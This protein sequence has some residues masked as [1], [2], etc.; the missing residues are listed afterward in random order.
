[1]YRLDIAINISRLLEQLSV[2]I[3]FDIQSL[4]KALVLFVELNSESWTPS[5]IIEQMSEQTPVYRTHFID[6]S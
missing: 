1:M 5:L 6:L 3:S 4:H 2:V